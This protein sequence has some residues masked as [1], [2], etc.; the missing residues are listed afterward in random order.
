MEIFRGYCLR[1]VDKKDF[2]IKPVLVAVEAPTEEAIDLPI[3][4]CK[5]CLSELLQAF[6]DFEKTEE[7]L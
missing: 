4:L 1:C 6:T 3:N 7:N 5:D 2:S